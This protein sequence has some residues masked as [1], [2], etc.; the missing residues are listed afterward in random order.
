MMPNM[1]WHL[2]TNWGPPTLSGPT[3]GWR[4]TRETLRFAL[5]LVWLLL[6]VGAIFVILGFVD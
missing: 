4:V 1:T 6:V 3:F 5:S 2:P